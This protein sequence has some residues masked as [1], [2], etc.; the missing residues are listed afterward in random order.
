VSTESQKSRWVPPPVEY[1]TP[2]DGGELSR[3][4]L[5]PGD[6][7]IITPSGKI[8]RLKRAGDVLEA[9]W[10]EHYSHSQ[11][12]RLLP[13]VNTDRVQSL[14][15]LYEFWKLAQDPEEVEVA[16]NAFVAAVKSGMGQHGGLTMLDWAMT[17]HALFEP[18]KQLIEEFQAQ[19]VVLYR[20]G[21]MVSSLSVL[22]SLACGYR[23]PVFLREIY[24]AAWY[25]DAG[26]ID[27]SFTYWVALACQAERTKPGEGGKFLITQSASEKEHALFFTHPRLSYERVKVELEALLNF[28]EL[29]LSVLHHHEKSDGSGFPE[30]S[31][32]SVLS[33]W[34][35]LMVLA[36]SLVDYREEVLEKNLRQGWQ[37]LWNVFLARP[38]QGLPV[39][40]VVD[41][42]T[43]WA[44]MTSPE[45]ESAA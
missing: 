29:L 7:F 43:V 33:D 11:Q 28:P 37:E 26:L 30:K 36:D 27:E 10:R 9:A 39:Q 34:E 1:L 45:K 20:R 22:F 25:L 23:D 14:T 21:L 40:S 24:Q 2:L 41:K 31:C 5:A 18:N 32:L 6:I 42:L 12:L 15:E 38:V 4:E 8:L 3:W 16:A 13:L 35:T 17:C 19:H 44:R